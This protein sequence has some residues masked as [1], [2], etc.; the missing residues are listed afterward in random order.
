M[1]S[2]VGTEAVDPN[3]RLFVRLIVRL[4]VEVAGDVVVAAVPVYGTVITTGDQPAGVV[5][6]AA[7]AFGF[8]ALH[9]EV[10]PVTAAPQL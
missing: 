6:T 9:V 1:V 7:G 2:D 5:P 3:T 8:R 10:E 4:V